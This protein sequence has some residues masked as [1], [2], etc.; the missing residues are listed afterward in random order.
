MYKSRSI[1]S[2]AIR[3]SII[4][5]L[6]FIAFALLLQVLHLKGSLLSYAQ[7]GMLAT[8]IYFSQRSYKATYQ[9]MTYGQG[10]KVGFWPPFFMALWT[11]L[12]VSSVIA[13]YGKEPIS[14]LLG[15]QGTTLQTTPLLQELLLG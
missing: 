4:T 6:I 3:P 7:R 1:W 13:W 12:L 15:G 10:V 2:I 9:Q 14:R 11:T 5:F 8:A